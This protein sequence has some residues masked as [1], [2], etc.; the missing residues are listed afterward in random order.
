MAR[1]GSK[2]IRNK[3]LKKINGISLVGLAGIIC[4]NISIIDKAIVSTNSNRIGKE[5]EKY[6]LDFFFKR[7]KLLS[8]GKVPDTLV[9]LHSLI[10]SEKFYNK[11]FD[12]IVSLPPTTPTRSI[13]EVEE[14]IKKLIN[15][16]YSSIW[17][18]NETDK[19]FHPEKSLIVK[20]HK[21]KFYDK[22]GDKLRARQLLPKIYHRNGVCYA[23]KRRLVF[24]KK[25]IDKNSS[26]F[27]CRKNH[28]SIDT[29]EDLKI[30]KKI[31]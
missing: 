13:Y 24:K 14:T 11:K 19:K 26:Y 4:Q 29:I 15:K 12:I 2:G 23:I 17:T 27:K 10:A 9:L 6:N 20:N 22:L 31:I 5:A 1:A 21:L 16:N 18:V 30:A 25:L 3:N 7:P 8:G 28:I